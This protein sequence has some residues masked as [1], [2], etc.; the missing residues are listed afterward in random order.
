MS[1]TRVTGATPAAIGEVLSH[2][3]ERRR[4]TILREARAFGKNYRQPKVLCNPNM[5]AY[6]SSDDNDFRIRQWRAGGEA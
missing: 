3:G 4:Q 2:Q 6:W 1:R 5:P